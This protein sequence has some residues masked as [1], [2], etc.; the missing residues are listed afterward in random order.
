MGI[1]NVVLDLLR[2]RRQM[3]L[4]F[5]KCIMSGSS[6]NRA[7]TQSPMLLRFARTVTENFTTVRMGRFWLS[8]YIKVSQ[9]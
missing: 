3:G 2:L 1:V 8:I 6:L 4:H 9:G 7:Q 5:L